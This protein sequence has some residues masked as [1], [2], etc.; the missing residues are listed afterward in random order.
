V[1]LYEPMMPMAWKV[2]SCKDATDRTR[3]VIAPTRAAPGVSHG[4]GF[5]NYA[6]SNSKAAAHKAEQSA[7]KKA[8]HQLRRFETTPMSDVYPPVFVGAAAP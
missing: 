6:S 3:R 4:H 7:H 2:C 5:S 8:A 1:V